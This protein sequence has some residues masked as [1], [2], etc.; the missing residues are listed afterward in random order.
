MPIPQPHPRACHPSPLDLVDL[1]HPHLAASP[2]PTTHAQPPI[3]PTSTQTAPRNLGRG[4]RA[5][6]MLHSLPLRPADPPP[7][8]LAHARTLAQRACRAPSARARGRRHAGNSAHQKT[9]Q[10]PGS[11]DIADCRARP[12]PG[13]VP[14]PCAHQH[15]T[16]QRRVYFFFTRRVR[17]CVWGGGG[18]PIP[19]ATRHPCL[20][21]CALPP[22]AWTAPRACTR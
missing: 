9:L 19:C 1:P 20:P 17:V 16:S 13:P 3:S 10:S 7:T 14:W 18:V 15:V 4:Q 8:T 22:S 2:S 5:A 11:A 12:R 21:A 6:H